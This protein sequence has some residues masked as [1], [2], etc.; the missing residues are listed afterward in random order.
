[1]PPEALAGVARV[2]AY[3][4]LIIDDGRVLHLWLHT[5]LLFL[6]EGVFLRAETSC[7]EIVFVPGH[8]D[9]DGPG[10]VLTAGQVLTRIRGVQ[11]RC[12]VVEYRC[13]VPVIIPD[14]DTRCRGHRACAAA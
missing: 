4:S 5:F 6:V 3:S 12:T 8:G 9:T 11:Y 2:G 10:P 7:G 14:K 13:T 1:M